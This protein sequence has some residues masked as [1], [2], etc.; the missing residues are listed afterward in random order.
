MVP[1][2]GAYVIGE[3]LITTVSIPFRRVTNERLRA[4]MRPTSTCEDAMTK[5]GKKQQRGRQRSGK[6]ERGMPLVNVN[7][8]GIDVGAKQHYVAVPPGRA[9]PAVRY[10]GT[11]T[12]DLQALAKWL[13]QC[14]V[15]TIAMESTGVYWIPLYQI[16]E[17]YGFTA[18]LVK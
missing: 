6:V 8:A 13:Q 7:A 12:E 15:S 10:F 17:S 2:A 5:T 16:L 9:E 3:D 14:G 4:A 11:F 18:K 1:D